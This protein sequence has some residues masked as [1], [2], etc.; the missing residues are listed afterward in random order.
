MIRTPVCELLKIE[1]PIALGG[2]G[3]ATSPE[4]VSAVSNAGGLGALGCHYLS[5]E[6]VRE[7]TAAI[8]QQTN[9][10]FGLNFLLFDTRED[11]FAA[12][13]ELRPAVMQFGWARPE[14]DLRTYFERAH[15]VGCL[16]TH[17]AGTVPEA[18]RAAKA[19]ADIVIAQGTEGG[20]HVGWMA[21]LP[22]I[23]M[24]VDAVAPIAVL[25]AGG[26]ADGRG[27]VAALALGADGIL[28]GTRFL[29]TIESPLH[30]NFKQAVVESDGHDT[31]LSEIP[32]IAAGLVWP[33]AMTRSR[34]NRFIERWA[35]RE[36]ALRRDRIKALEGLNAARKSGDVEEG[37][38]SMGQDAG[39]IYDIPPAGD[40]VT[41]I[42]QQAEEILI[43]KMPRLIVR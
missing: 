35:G 10:P 14:Q 2:M 26:F 16:V 8:R 7:R 4:L 32:D 15:K 27:L 31:Q 24:V 41:R 38:L 23:P 40:I 43:E 3:S 12:A 17:M 28:L 42:A 30:P 21:S 25:A 22:L 13:L 5:P 39:L 29:A 36:W 20:G 11:S 37:P 19:G 6:Q 1:H 9:K 33:G 34:R 18:V